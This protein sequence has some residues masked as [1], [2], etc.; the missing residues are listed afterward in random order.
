MILAGCFGAP[1]PTKDYKDAREQDVK[2]E[3]PIDYTVQTE[4]TIAR[5][6]AMAWAEKG[7]AAAQIADAERHKREDILTVLR[8]VDRQGIARVR[9]WLENRER[10]H[11]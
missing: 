11:P 1:A 6:K 3:P 4:H 5:A 7:K 8:I 2:T 10:M 9:R